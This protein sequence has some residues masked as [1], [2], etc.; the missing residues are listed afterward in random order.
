MHCKRF[1]LLLLPALV[2]LSD[3]RAQTASGWELGHRLEI[4]ANYRDS[5]EERF[6]LR[7]PFPPSFLP[8]GQT[9]G[10]MQT[11]DPGEN[12]E[13]S[14]ASL[15]LDARYGW[16]AARAKVH[17]IDKYRANP[18]SNDRTA[19]IDE[20]YI[21]LGEM[22]EFLDRPDGTSFFALA[23]KSPR[24]E[25][26]PVRLLES[27]GLAANSFNRF[28]DVQAIVGGTLGRNFYWRLQGANGNP[29]YFRDPNALAGDNGIPELLQ[30]NP[31]PDLKSGFPILYNAETEDL[32]PETD[33]VQFGQ[34]VGYRW[35]NDALTSGF[36]VIF[37]HYQRDLAD[38][39]DL[40]GTFYGGDLDLLNG[41]LDAGLPLEGRN[42]EEYGGRVYA[43]LGGLTAIGQYTRQ[44]IAGLDRDGWEAELGYR[45]A[46]GTLL[47]YVQPAVRASD[48][49]NDFSGNAAVHPSPSI[50]W[51][52]QKY[53]AGVRIGFAGNV[54]VT[55]E[56]TVH[57]VDAPR[58]L[59]LDE[60]LVTLRWRL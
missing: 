27:Y 51:S 25:R 47:E 28:E 17:A 44:E 49:Q 43:E 40:T 56:H 48:L 53:D 55:V 21:V 26:Q 37:F 18:T 14:V 1:V 4:R 19:D 54:D 39:V 52:W 31:D 5:A 24:M 45:F 3:A 34:A 7:F 30:P 16:F 60:T 42:K 41:P 15:Q 59:D 32:F 20:L 50:W 9:A 22:P 57:E 33:H 38:T 46:V 13:L 35:Q 6:Q 29:L 8:V 58:E 2:C 10:F 11:V 23:G 36:D 12:F